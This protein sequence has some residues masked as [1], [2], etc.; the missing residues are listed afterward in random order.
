MQS[1]SVGCEGRKERSG[2][3]SGQRECSLA[4]NCAAVTAVTKQS[5]SNNRSVLSPRQT[6]ALRNKIQS[7]L[8]S[9]FLLSHFFSF[10]FG[11]RGGLAICLLVADHINRRAFRKILDSVE[12]HASGVIAG[13]E[14]K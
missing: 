10:F 3:V 1:S 9:V 11:V 14:I 4:C 8:F 12:R 13:F 6:P 2:L 7:A 5:F